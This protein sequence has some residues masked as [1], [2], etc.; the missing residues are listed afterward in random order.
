MHLDRR[1]PQSAKA[2]VNRL[3]GQLGPVAIAAEM[4]EVDPSQRS[5][6]QLR[7]HFGCCLVGKV[8]VPAQNP[9][10]G[11]P[12]APQVVLQKLEVVIGLQQQPADRTDT[13]QDEAGHMPQVRK[14]PQLSR[15]RRQYQAHRIHGIVGNAE[16]PDLK[17]PKRKHSARLK[18]RKRHPCRGELPLDGFPGEPVGVDRDLQA[19]R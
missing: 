4:S 16:S 2:S 14:D 3:A 17:V 1:G 13:L 6:R 18:H 11:A 10:F 7:G 12:G 8:P 15:R 19:T 5:R 9:L